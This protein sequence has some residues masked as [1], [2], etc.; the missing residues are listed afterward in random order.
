MDFST[1]KM[2]LLPDNIRIDAELKAK[3]DTYLAAGGKLILS[4]ESGLWK[5]RE[6]FAFDLGAEYGGL[7]EFSPDYILPIPE[8]RPDFVNSPQVMYMTS[9]RIRVTSGQSLGDVID[10]Y[11]NRT[12]KHFCSHQ[13]TPY[14]TE[15]SGY[16]CG[17]RNGNILYFAHPVFSQYRGYGAVAYREFITKAIRW[18]A[19]KELTVS[20][21]LPSTARLSLT[22]Q[23]GEKRSI[24]HLLYASTI[25][26]GGP[27]QLS[28][29]TVATKGQSIEVI[30][31]LLPLAGTEVTLKYP[32]KVSR[33][34]LE[35][36][37]ESLPYEQ[38]GDQLMLKVPP[39]VCHQMVVLHDA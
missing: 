4:G 16:A 17:V 8:L 18:F 2:I 22:R 13:H 27:V 1:Y 24:L 26:R 11:F 7:T 23:A 14:R 19:G 29:G 37:G 20:A 3:L 15:P 9:H 35:P 34:T 25:N 30:E 12:Y 5:D 36:Q 6:E 28:G 32:Q 33:V 10:P 31:E 39:F 21:N 38:A